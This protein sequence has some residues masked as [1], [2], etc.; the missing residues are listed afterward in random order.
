[1]FHYAQAFCYSALALCTI[2]WILYIG[3]MHEKALILAAIVTLIE[4]LKDN[5]RQRL[6]KL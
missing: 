3:V 5:N 1:M 6:L 2:A 4:L